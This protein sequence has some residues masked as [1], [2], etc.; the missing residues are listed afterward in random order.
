MARA[1]APTDSPDEWTAVPDSGDRYSSGIPDFDRLI[2]G[3]FARGS[4]ALL[5]LDATIATEELDLFLTPLFLNFLYQSRGILAVLPSRDSP[6]AFRGRLTRYATRRRFDSR[7][8]IVTYVGED[9]ELPYVVHLKTPRTGFTK[10]AREKVS[11]ESMAKM[12]TAETAVSGVRKRPFLEMNAFEVPEML[13]GAETASRMFFHGIKRARA[14]Q[15]L[16]VGLTR[17]GLQCSPAVEAMADSEF[18][19]SRESVGLTVRGIRPAFGT[20]VVTIDR[21]RGAPYVS[22]VPGPPS[23]PR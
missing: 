14:V 17:P 1:T 13:F 22:L 8:R 4:F 15:N 23:A 18:A 2:G 5:R 12:V 7:V 20:H 16:I 21:A 11:A 6:H 9:E 19:L 10:A 3:G